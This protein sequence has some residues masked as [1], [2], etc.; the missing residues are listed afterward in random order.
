MCDMVKGDGPET[1]SIDI[2]FKIVRDTIDKNV[3]TRSETKYYRVFTQ[4]AC[5]RR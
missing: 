3:L 4:Q 5:Y 2:P 1:V